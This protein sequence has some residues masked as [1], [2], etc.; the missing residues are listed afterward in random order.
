MQLRRGEEKK[1][2][3]LDGVLTN[4]CRQSL[5]IDSQFQLLPYS[6]D[7]CV[8]SCV[9]LLLARA[10]THQHAHT[11]AHTVI[12]T[13]TLHISI[14]RILTSC[15]SRVVSYW[16]SGGG[17]DFVCADTNVYNFI[18]CV[19]MTVCRECTHVLCMSV[20]SHVSISM[21]VYV[22]VCMYVC[23]IYM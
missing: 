23:S 14:S 17:G 3:K 4:W 11:R 8:P 10:H 12:H 19:S 5:K 15:N 2:S 6:F 21:Y 1:G 9:E 18:V 7:E 20:C 22:C 13:H 16:V